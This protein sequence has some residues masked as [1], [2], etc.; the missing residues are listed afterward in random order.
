[1]KAIDE[2]VRVIKKS[3]YVWNGKVKIV[4][5]NQESSQKEGGWRLIEMTTN[6]RMR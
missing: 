1:M 3:M 5:E 4:F 6:I 2:F